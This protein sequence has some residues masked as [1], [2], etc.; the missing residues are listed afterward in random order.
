MRGEMILI[1]DEL[2]SGRLG[3]TNA[4]YAASALW[5]LDL[6]FGVIQ[7]VGDN[8]EDIAQAFQLAKRADFVIVSGGLGTTEDDITNE[9]AAHFFELELVEHPKKVSQLQELAAKRHRRFNAA[10]RRMAL[11]PSGVE[12][13]DAICAGWFY[14]DN[15][16]RP[17]FFL[18]GVPF[19][20]T[21][22]VDEQV[23]P[24]LSGRFVGQ[25]VGNRYISV[26][27]ITEA[28]VG[29]RIEGLANQVP[30]AG[31]GYY[32]VFPEE[33]LV[34]TVRADSER[35][36]NQRL[37]ELEDKIC[38]RLGEHVV[39]RGPQN[40]EEVLGKILAERELT[41]AVAESCSGGGLA[42]RIT[43]VAGAS[44]Y[45]E[46]GFVTYSNQSKIDLLGVDGAIISQHGA[47]S[48]ACA[49]AMAEGA[50]SASGTDL[51]LAIT[52]IAGPGGGTEEKPAGTVFLSLAAPQGVIVEKHWYMGA[53]N[54]VQT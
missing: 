39:V 19:E 13:L 27:G 20:F 17:W 21:R 38:E 9:C 53:R 25:K 50:R 29:R 43:S 1:G 18:P 51:A 12:V 40:L 46:R 47:V 41:L 16:G 8:P 45:F 33:K 3:D 14:Q 34:L 49:R 44:D 11:M 26:F 24:Y 35:E 37:D 7:M 2:I 48:E 28:E 31:V 5:A 15:Q 30:G 22:M 52:G 42:R 54:W 6:G 36:L 4:R 10:H 32:P 23:L